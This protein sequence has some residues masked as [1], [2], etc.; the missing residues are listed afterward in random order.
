[1][2][3]LQ[4]VLS[5]RADIASDAISRRGSVAAAD[6]VVAGRARSG[7]CDVARK[8]AVVAFRAVETLVCKRSQGDAQNTASVENRLLYH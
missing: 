1:M 3:T 4:A 7:G 6:A 5:L 8:L 2:H